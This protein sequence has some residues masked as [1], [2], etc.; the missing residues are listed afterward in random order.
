MTSP[1]VGIKQQWEPR[2]SKWIIQSLSLPFKMSAMTRA[3]LALSLALGASAAPN[4]ITAP[5]GAETLTV[6]LL[7]GKCAL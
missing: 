6:G 2:G 3:G 7:G 5:T 4:S 1:L